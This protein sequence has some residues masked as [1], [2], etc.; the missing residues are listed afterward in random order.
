MTKHHREMCVRYTDTTTNVI[1]ALGGSA[2]MHTRVRMCL[3][4]RGGFSVSWYGGGGGCEL[5]I[6]HHYTLPWLYP[7]NEAIRFYQLLASGWASTR[8]SAVPEAVPT[9]PPSLSSTRGSDKAA[10]SGGPHPPSLPKHCTQKRST[11][12]ER[13]PK[14][15]ETQVCP[16]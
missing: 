14:A 13:P 15:L 12:T 1:M 4:T 16:H 10:R 5:R 9:T 6:S 11:G 2:Y 8:S 7:I 3:C